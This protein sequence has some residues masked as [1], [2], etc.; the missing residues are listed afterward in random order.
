MNAIIGFTTLA[1]AHI[2]RKDRVEGYL[3]KIMTS[4]NHLLSLINDILDM[5]HIE[6]GKIQLEEKPCSL[7][8][9]LQGLRSIVQADVYAKQQTFHMDLSGI[10]N[11]Q[12]CCDTKG[13][14]PLRFPL[15]AGMRQGG[16]RTHSV[17]M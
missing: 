4:G 10:Q 9:I 6:S 16:H 3:K 15:K 8:E 5:S 1:V 7:P 2:D 12:I 14:K 17:S 13:R 11:E